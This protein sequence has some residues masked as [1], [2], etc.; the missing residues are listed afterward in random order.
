[1]KQKILSSGD[2]IAD[3]RADRARGLADAR[4]FAE[5]AD[6]MRQALE[7]VPGWAAG[8][9]RLATY[10]EKAGDAN[11]ACEALRTVLLLTD[12][13]IFGAGLK[14]AA[15]GQ[16]S[17]PPAPPSA[18]VERLFD[19]YADRF[20]RALVERLGYSVPQGLGALLESECGRE[21]AFAHAVDLGCGTGLM[22]ERLRARVSYLEGYDLSAGMLAKARR[23]GIYDHLASFDLSLSADVAGLPLRGAGK[24]DLVT[25]ADVVAYLGDVDR[26]FATVAAILAPGGLFAFS[27]ERGAEESEWMLRP[28]LRYAH[29]EAYLKRRAEMHGMATVSVRGAQLRRDGTEIVEGLLVLMERRAAESDA[30]TGLHMMAGPVE[31]PRAG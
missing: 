12:D 27:V 8:W 28:S 10:L 4:A 31:R 15:L 3:R 24:A 18:F 17:A 5:A 29:G 21:A 1:M 14:L 19:D 30:T 16:A 23:K 7:L 20:D 6:L 2:L 9:F 26:L 11:G 13:D 25:A 22:G